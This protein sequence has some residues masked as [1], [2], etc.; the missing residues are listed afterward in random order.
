MFKYDKSNL[1]S[2][3]NMSNFK[4]KV[5]DL[6]F[7][8]KTYWK[9]PQPGYQVSIKEFVAFA[10]GAG[11]PSF[12]S[13]LVSFTTIATSVNI[14]VSYFGLTTGLAWILG[15][16]GSAI[17]LIRA[18][19][20]SLIIDNSK[21]KRGKFKPFLLLS[22]IGAAVCFCLIPFTPSVFTTRTAFSFEMFAIPI[23]NIEQDT[24]NVTVGVIAVFT[25]NQIGLFFHTLMTQCVTGIE[26]NITVV[27]QER[28]NIQAFKGL[29]CNIPGSLVNML[30]PVLAGAFFTSGT[31]ASSSGYNNINLYRWVFPFCAVGSIILIMFMVRGTQE[32]AVVSKQK[33]LKSNLGKNIWQLT[34]NKY[35]WIINIF[36]VAI[37]IRALANI[38]S[39]LQ[40]YTYESGLG[41]TL[42][43]L[44][45]TTLLMNVLVIGMVTGPLFIK[46]FGKKKVLLV[47][48]IMYSGAIGLQFLAYNRPII[49][50]LT[51]LL[52]NIA[53]GYAYAAIIM[54]SD[55]L[56][57][58]Q[59]KTGNRVEGTW[60]NY[61][62]VIMTVL[63]IFTSLLSPIFLQFAGVKFSDFL[64]DKLQDET[65]RY[66]IYKYQT[67]LALIA[68]VFCVL[69]ILFY[70]LSEKKHAEIIKAL[71]IRAAIDN[72]IDHELEDKDVLSLKE[73]MDY[74]E[75]TKSPLIGKE[76][77]R[78]NAK[79]IVNEILSRYDE[80]KASVDAK[81]RSEAISDFVR[82]CE[83]AFKRTD[84]LVSIARK[85]AQKKNVPFDEDGTKARLL[86][87][88]RV[89]T[90]LYDGDV[91]MY[92]DMQS[93]INDTEKAFDTY[94]N[95]IKAEAEEMF[96]ENVK[97]EEAKLLKKMAEAKL[98]AEKKGKP[99]SESEF[100]DKFVK[101]SRY[102]KK[103]D[104]YKH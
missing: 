26:Q 21:S 83:L 57:Y 13:V 87:Q 45:C 70:D 71:Y 49:I 67:L 97:S 4:K 23:L 96:E 8:A 60:Q 61:S 76:L 19:I 59:Y 84:N 82:D 34:K 53:S 7:K 101:N 22:T 51:Q 80:V 98:K 42:I 25:L 56:D 81:I 14:M 90:Y 77:E 24:V 35:F 65:M 69:P 20:L 100:T 33:H 36:N 15:I 88:Q 12:M 95:S 78:E 62:S 18:P 102:L 43:G 47:T 29:I 66:E 28:A 2:G 92:P 93:I 5:S 48:S 54:V 11:G 44:Y 16:F 52:Q 63:G 46:K 86:S 9:K 39:W 94:E 104:K 85:N 38:T 40:Q 72:Y 31:D 99:F 89:L 41:K 37:G 10:I 3:G 73:A 27:A 6:L 68:S 75:E 17:A 74:Y 58:H 103:S 1:N 79:E 50:L 64:P 91:L 32:R 30:I 55:V